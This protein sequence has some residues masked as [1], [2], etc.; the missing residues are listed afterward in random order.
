MKN[1]MVIT[2]FVMALQISPAIISA[3]DQNY[4]VLEGVK[5]EIGASREQVKALFKNTFGVMS[6]ENADRK[7]MSFYTGV[8]RYIGEVVFSDGRVVA[9]HKHWGDY[10]ADL[11]GLS[12]FQ[13]FHTILA[14]IAEGGGVNAQLWTKEESRP[15]SQSRYVFIRKGKRT[16]IMHIEGSPQKNDVK[17]VHIDEHLEE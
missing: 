13:V 2:L 4:L 10:Y 15:D 3:A 8:D 9:V 17:M 12:P 6:T 14:D 1:S 7:I 11:A 5:V 16:A